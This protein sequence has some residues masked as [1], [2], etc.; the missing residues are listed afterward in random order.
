LF[1]LGCLYF[2]LNQA[3]LL[4]GYVIRDHSLVERLMTQPGVVLFY[5]RQILLP[6]VGQMSLYIDDFGV[7]R[8]LGLK[9]V[10][11]IAGIVLLG[12]VTL[13]A[14]RSH[15]LI[16][17]GLGMFLLSHILESTFIPLEMVFEHRNYFGLW[18]IALAVVSIVSLFLTRMRVQYRYLLVAV[19]LSILSFQTY[20]R[21]VVWSDE[22]L[23][24]AFAAESR[25][26]SRRS[27]TAF[28]IALAKQGQIELAE[29]VI[30]HAEKNGMDPAYTALRLISLKGMRNGVQSEDIERALSAIPDQP[31]M[32]RHGSTLTDIR[33]NFLQGRFDRP[34]RADMLALFETLA[35]HKQPRLKSLDRAR[36][37]G[38]YA[39]LL[40]Q[41]GQLDQAL[42]RINEAHR[43]Y[44][45]E[46]EV[47]VLKAEIEHAAGAEVAFK[48]TMETIIGEAIELNSGQYRRIKKLLSASTL[49]DVDAGADEVH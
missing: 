38:M 29:K 49:A 41:D 4:H 25:P 7:A 40:R 48:E 26:L 12:L 8:E 18:G 24:S 2:Y 36:L 22:F 6:D 31:L 21:A 42:R 11:S 15:P 5:I 16:S 28:A 37:L 23:H 3:S 46:T 30:E 14:R 13:L 32:I 19:C 1:C 33:T 34:D 47:M 27:Q 9:T 20:G 35:D 43:F 44:P 10:L 17:L 39:E 45:D